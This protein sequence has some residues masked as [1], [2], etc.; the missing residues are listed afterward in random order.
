MHP[1]PAARRAATAARRTLLTGGLLTAGA[2]GAASCAPAEDPVAAARDPLAELDPAIWTATDLDSLLATAPSAAQGAAPERTRALAQHLVA[3]HMSPRALQDLSAPAV[4]ERLRAHA[5]PLWG[6]PLEDALRG[7][8]RAHF[9][10]QFAPPRVPV[11]PARAC[12]RWLLAEGRIHLAATIAHTVIDPGTGEVRVYAP[13]VLLSILADAPELTEGMQVHAVMN[14]ADLCAT[15]QAGGLVVPSGT[16]QEA[17]RGTV[18]A[19]PEIPEE[20]V[21]SPQEGLFASEGTANSSC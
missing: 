14:G 16:E 7:P 19:A 21:L 3:V 17:L 13:Q 15:Q 1:A 4:I 12:P 5:G 18:I 11:G 10:T 6:P 20:S 8:E 2:L 9:S